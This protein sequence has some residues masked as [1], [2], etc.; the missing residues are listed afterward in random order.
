MWGVVG[1]KR[2][3]LVRNIKKEMVKIIQNDE[4]TKWVKNHV[5]KL[6]LMQDLKW[7]RWWI[8]SNIMMLENECS[9]KEIWHAFMQVSSIVVSNL[10][11]W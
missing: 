10:D 7:Q 5:P 2:F 4:M 6:E 1:C 11:V 3:N 9:C 8:M